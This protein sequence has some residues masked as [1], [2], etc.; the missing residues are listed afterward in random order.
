M[1]GQVPSTADNSGGMTDM[2]IDLEDD[3]NFAISKTYECLRE[4]D[5]KDIIMLEKLDEEDGLA[6]DG[7]HTASYLSFIDAI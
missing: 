3:F 4:Q 1:I 6:M 7:N 2:C 5:P